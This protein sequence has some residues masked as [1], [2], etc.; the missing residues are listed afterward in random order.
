MLIVPYYYNKENEQLPHEKIPFDWEQQHKNP[1]T[2]IRIIKEVK[3]L[4]Y[5][6]S[7]IIYDFYHRRDFAVASPYSNEERDA[8]AAELARTM[9]IAL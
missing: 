6:S 2:C 1:A 5:L 8:F 9:A 7:E 3:P 4:N